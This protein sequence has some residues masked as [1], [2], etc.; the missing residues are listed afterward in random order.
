MSSLIDQVDVKTMSNAKCSGSDTFY[1]ASD[2]TANMICAQDTG[3]DSC[4]NDGGGPLVT[5]EGS[6]YSIIG[7]NKDNH[8]RTPHSVLHFRCCLLELWLCPG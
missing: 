6:Y 2:I 4:Y 8:L 1:S 3:K 7:K 5:N